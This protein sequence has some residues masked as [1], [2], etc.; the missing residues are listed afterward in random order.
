MSLFELTRDISRWAH[1]SVFFSIRLCAVLKLSFA[2]LSGLYRQSRLWPCC[3]LNLNGTQNFSSQKVPKIQFVH[4]GESITSKVI[5]CTLLSQP[6]KLSIDVRIVR[7]GCLT[8]K[9][10]RV[11]FVLSTS[12]AIIFVLTHGPDATSENRHAS[13]VKTRCELVKVTHLQRLGYSDHRSS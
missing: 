6:T 2:I 7:T 1:K 4:A 8:C 5:L 12:M 10:R 13:N 9:A 11:K 3:Y